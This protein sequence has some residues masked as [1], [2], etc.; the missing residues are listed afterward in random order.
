MQNTHALLK[1]PAA[2][3]VLLALLGITAHASAILLFTSRDAFQAQVGLPGLS[4]NFNDL[5]SSGGDVLHAINFGSMVVAGDILVDAGAL[6]FRANPST[7]VLIN[8]TSNMFAWGADISP[9]G[10]AGLINFSVGG[11]SRLIN[12]S[13]PGFVGFATDFPFS[14]IN[15][16]L[17][18]AD[19]IG[20]SRIDFVIDNVIANAVPDSVPEPSTLMLLATGAGLFGFSYRRRKHTQG[21]NEQEPKEEQTDSM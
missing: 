2:V 9:I 21:R 11:L 12:V 1:K 3:V 20:T 16:N 19:P 14:A 10:G 17:G 18:V 5:A 8:F 15:I 6:R 13:S 7:Q 4:F